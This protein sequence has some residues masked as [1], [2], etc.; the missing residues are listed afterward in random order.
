MPDGSVAAGQARITAIAVC[1]VCVGTMLSAGSATVGAVRSVLAGCGT[2]AADGADAG[3]A[4]TAL[5]AVTV[6][7]YE[8]PLVKPVTEQLVAPVVVH[9][10][11]PGAEVAV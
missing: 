1:N 8:T 7:V 6:N 4:P 9:V 11:P 5:E 2:T 10:R 3:P